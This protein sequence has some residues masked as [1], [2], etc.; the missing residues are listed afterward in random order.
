MLKGLKEFIL[1]G[2]I[3]ELAIAVVIGGA[4]AAVVK[5]FTDAII[6]PFINAIGGP[7][8]AGFGF[9]LRSGNDATFV[10]I[11]GL[12]NALI[13]FAITAAVV[14][15]IFVVPMKHLAERR[16]RGTEPAPVVPSETDILVE[17][18]DLLKAQNSGGL[19]K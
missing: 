9:Y 6:L 7:G 15:F 16:A 11:G 12:V 8:S 17:I 10:N 5:S 4:F 3:V 18:R 2:N 19:T 1:R 14:Y 13:T